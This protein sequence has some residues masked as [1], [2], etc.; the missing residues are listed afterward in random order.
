MNQPLQDAIE[1][2][3]LNELDFVELFNWHLCFGIVVSDFDSFA[4]CFPSKHENP[5]I[6]C[7]IEESDTLFVSM[8]SGNMRKALKKSTSKF[9]YI[10]F[11]RDFKNSPHIRVY[12]MTKFYSKLK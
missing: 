10:S 3:K 6:P 4:L 5:R 8:H 12:D 7:E 2:Y 9:K 11:Q 1:I